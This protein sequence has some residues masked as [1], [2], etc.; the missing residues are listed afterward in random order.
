MSDKLKDENHPYTNNHYLFENLKKLRLKNLKKRVH[1]AAFKVDVDEN[2]EAVVSIN[3]VDGIVDDIFD[4]MSCDE[5]MVQEIDFGLRAYGKVAAKRIID[6]IPMII[7]RCLLM[8]IPD[9][10]LTRQL[11]DLQ[12][13]EVLTES[14]VSKTHRTE[15]KEKV[16]KMEK[17]KEAIK[18]IL[19]I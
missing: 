7:D 9:Q 12:L 3:T 16:R 14:S 6:D 4:S 18:S 10:I 13:S 19:R 15:L 17:A 5:H 1:E 11:T 2:E 8:C